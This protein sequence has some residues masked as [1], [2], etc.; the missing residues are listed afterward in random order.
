MNKGGVTVIDQIHDI[1]QIGY[2]PVGQVGAALF[3]RLG[4]NV[5]VFERHGGLYALPRAGH[6]DHEIVRNFQAIGAAEDVLKDAYRCSTYGW[7]N[8]HGETLIDIDWSQDGISGWASDYLMYQPYVEDALDRAARRAPSV[9]IHQG[10][11]AVAIEQHSDHVE[12]TFAAGALDDSGQYIHTGV[13][14]TAR[15]RYLIGA[16][17][18]NST[19]RSS[20]GIELEDL[21]F[22]ERWLV[23][24]FRQKR[25]LSFEFDN[26]QICDP[27]RPMC[28]FQLGKSHRRFEFM[29]LPEDEPDTLVTPEAV[30]S[31]V[32]RWLSPEDAD[33]I[34]STIYTFRS[35]NARAWRSDRILLAGDAAHLMPPFLGQGM[36]SGVRDVANL[37]WKLDLVLRG[38][39]KDT[40]LDSYIVERKPHVSNIIEQAVALGKVSCTVDVEA[41][42]QRDEAFFTHQVPPPPPFPWIEKGILQRSPSVSAAAVV[43][44][45][46]LQARISRGE[47]P[48]ALADDVVGAGW[49]L[50]SRNGAGAV[51]SQ[52]GRAVIGALGVLELNFAGRDG[53]IVDH[54]GLYGRYFDETGID[55]ILVRPDFYVF[56]AVDPG[57]TADGL[58][59]DLADQ[60]GLAAE[61]A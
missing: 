57:Q 14:R 49:Q 11:E 44:Q 18:A 47:G 40:L 36:C 54:D 43:G 39:A 10:W 61:T 38:Q 25:D 46:G 12:A 9:Q 30:W 33:L 51:E 37:A 59:I 19:T 8:Q 26:G 28:L 56:G 45:L 16:D 5:A 22:R 58:L 1:L 3:G 4:H 20:A 42:R 6:V 35:A 50:I 27:A 23:V 15:G 60:L 29:V 41:A 2:G 32:S 55:A 13:R 34:R 48:A 31:L 24:D 17:G 53:K 7:R 52:I 21:G